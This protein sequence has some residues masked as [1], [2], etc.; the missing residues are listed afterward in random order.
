MEQAIIQPKK[1]TYKRVAA[2]VER[3]MELFGLLEW[4]YCLE[5]VDGKEA[6]APDSDKPCIGWVETNI[7]RLEIHIVVAIDHTWPDVVETVIHELIHVVLR[8]VD[9]V[10]DMMGDQLSPQAALVCEEMYKTQQEIALRRLER[11]ITSLLFDEH[12]SPGG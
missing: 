6:T 11:G 5:L 9:V 2:V 4:V 8:S 7:A 10:V 3:A 12:E 1:I